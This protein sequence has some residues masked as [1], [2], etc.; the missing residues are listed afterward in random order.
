MK[1]PAK[2]YDLEALKVMTGRNTIAKI[3]EVLDEN[4]IKYIEGY[5]TISTCPE[6]IINKSDGT[7]ENW[8]V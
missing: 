6:A 8:D 3:K 4:G 1:Q 7:K 5:K 2:F